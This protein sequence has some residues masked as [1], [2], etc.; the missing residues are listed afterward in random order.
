MEFNTTRLESFEEFLILEELDKEVLID[1]SIDKN[2][3]TTE[4]YEKIDKDDV[5]NVQKKNVSSQHT[6]K[7]IAWLAFFPIALMWELKSAISKKIRIQKMIKKEDD[8][9]KR[10]E[11]KGELKALQQKEVRYLQQINK[12]REKAKKKAEKI[13][14]KKLASKED[15]LIKKQEEYKKAKEEIADAK[16]T[17]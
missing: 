17:E 4:L 2:F 13:D 16:K 5:D 9:V 6:G 14:K 7:V 3:D 1:E 12:A 10:T 8:P 11:L 15:M